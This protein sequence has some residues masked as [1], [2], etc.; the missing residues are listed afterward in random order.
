MNE[1]TYIAITIGPIGNA[2]S[3]ADGPGALWCA[4]ALFSDLSYRI[5]VGIYHTWGEAACF[6]SPAFCGTS[7]TDGTSFPDRIFVSLSTSVKPD[8]AEALPKIISEA[9][10]E[11]ADKLVETVSTVFLGESK[12]LRSFLAEYFQINYII[13]PD[14][15][16]NAD[17]KNCILNLDD[18]LN[19]L[20]CSSVLPADCTDHPLLTLFNS[21]TEGE[22]SPN[23]YLRNCYLIR[24]RE[25]V[26]K[27][28]LDP[29]T[30]MLRDIDAIAGGGSAKKGE[31]AR[32]YFAVL[33][34]DGDHIGDLLRRL[35]CDTDVQKFSE[36]CLRYNKA[37]TELVS[38]FG[39]MT[40][41]AGGD[42]LLCLLPLR[43]S[44][45]ENLL[46]FSETLT[47]AFDQTVVEIYR[48]LDENA[49]KS[50]DSPSV[51]IGIS[52]NFVKFPLYE[53][54]NAA[55][56]MLFGIAKE[57][58]CSIAISVR[59]ASGQ[60]VGLLIPNKKGGAASILSLLINQQWDELGKQL[61]CN[62]DNAPTSA[63][64]VSRS[65]HSVLYSLYNFNYGFRM[66]SA[67]N[68]DTENL[69]RNFFD[70]SAH[71]ANRTYI[72]MIQRICEQQRKKPLRKAILGNKRCICEQRRKKPL[73]KAILGNK[74][75]KV[76]CSEDAI[77]DE[78]C[79]CVE[80]MLRFAKLYSEEAGK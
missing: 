40:I 14:H 77:S 36:A 75:Y 50:I 37:A 60:S 45:G 76:D 1:K 63:A 71:N 28:L 47:D 56:S 18:I 6:L 78:F 21:H 69:F 44:N 43:G 58:R 24:D 32:N 54:L 29:E 46:Q 31:K 30:K 33:Y 67:K 52:V 73:C 66:C 80:A 9:K 62:S 11:I 23:A 72:N 79:D 12:R 49:R 41:Y 16:A 51:S 22:A 20:E 4:S 70:S 68:I 2:M 65:L 48:G 10:K 38:K 8:P 17:E 26:I 74:R 64:E 53:A 59:K 55:R 25:D 5:C 34:A 35:P 3:L 27:Q 15:I 42:D 7:D 61:A 39:G 19:S 57:D 13:A